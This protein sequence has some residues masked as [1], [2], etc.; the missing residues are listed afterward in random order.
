MTD[1]APRPAA[2][3]EFRHQ[4]LL[5][6]GQQGFLD[7]SVP[8]I[9]GGLEAE[10][11]TLVMV[12][13]A[14]IDLL[15]DALESDRDQVLFADMTGVGANPARIIPAWREFAGRHAAR[16]GALRGIGEPIWSGRNAAELVE[17]QRHESLLNIAFADSDRFQL[18]C[19]YD[20]ETL[21]QRVIEEAARSHPHLVQ[22]SEVTDSETYR[23]IEAIAAPFDDP[24]P[25]PPADVADVRF[26]ALTLSQLRAFLRREGSATGIGGV[27]LEGFVTA[28]NEVATNSVLHGGG[29][30][31]AQLWSED[32]GLVCQVRDG[33]KLRD[34]LAG[35]ERPPADQL[36]GRGL[37]LANQL[38]DLIQ[39][40][41]LPD[42]T[43]TRV[44]ARR[45]AF[46]ASAGG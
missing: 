42:G 4:A 27:A 19:P 18:L 28:V 9:R 6:G 12:A 33:G 37:W 38:C 32:D 36:E 5:Y 24:L 3:R 21:E 8:F 46:P 30:G 11:P 23:G 26:A 13:P 25:E 35:R 7:G 22:N 43:I 29:S 41:S 44:H 39:I 16:G 15:R 2:E 14:K 31:R 10:E 17:S 34:P 45:D 20:T 1:S 40:R